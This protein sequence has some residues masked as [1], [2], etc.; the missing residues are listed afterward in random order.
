[1]ALGR[2]WEW[3]GF[4]CVSDDFLKRW[5][6]FDYAL[7]EGKWHD[8]VDWYVWVPGYGTNVK[9]RSGL[10]TGDCLKFKR[11]QARWNQL[12]LWNEDADDIYSFPRKSEDIVSLA[13]ELNVKLP[14][15]L[16]KT[17]HFQEALELFQNATPAVQII[18]VK[19]HRQPRMYK[20]ANAFVLIEVAKITDPEEIKSVCVESTVELAK[21]A[22]P[23][24]L[25]EARDSVKAAVEDLGLEQEKLVSMNYLDALKVWSKGERLCNVEDGP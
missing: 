7:E 22:G 19:K 12:Q 1:M 9:L 10:A 17:V 23:K 8:V 18:E 25:A 4:G 14:D 2:H 11:L 5:A 15:R 3:R 16:K 21:W 24:E 13:K 6:T 20:G